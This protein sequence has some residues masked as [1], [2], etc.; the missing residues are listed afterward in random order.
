MKNNILVNKD[1]LQY[2]YDN[3]GRVSNVTYSDSTGLIY[4]RLDL[5]YDGKKLIKLDRERKS[6]NDFIIDKTLTMSYYPDGNLLELTY[7]YLPVNGQSEAIYTDRFEQYDN[8]LNVDG[9]GLIHNEFFDHLVLLPDIQLQ[10]NNPGKE[11]RTGQA[12][13]Y[14]VDYTYTYNDKNAPVTKKGNL[15]LLTGANAGR[16]FETSEAFTYY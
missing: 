8:K 12:E 1:R 10:K 4:T 6:G 2:I 14:L 13:N 5:S 11:S 15:I 9:F 16:R 7:H 3:A